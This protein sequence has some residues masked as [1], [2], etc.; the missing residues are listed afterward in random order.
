VGHSV[1]HSVMSRGQKTQPF[2]LLKTFDESIDEKR[3]LC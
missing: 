2:R 3:L 1:H